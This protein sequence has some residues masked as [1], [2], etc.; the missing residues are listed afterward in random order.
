MLR[1]F[2]A[3]IFLTG[4]IIAVPNAYCQRN[5]LT[6]IRDSTLNFVDSTYRNN[7]QLVEDIIENLSSQ[8]N[9][10]T[11]EN[12]KPVVIP[13]VVHVVHHTDVE[14]IST[15]QINSQ[16]AILNNDFNLK[17]TDTFLVPQ[18][19]K[20]LSANCKISFK[21]ATVDPSGNKSDGIRRIKTNV[22]EFYGDEVK[23]KQSGGDNAWP[24]NSYLNIW[25]CNL[26]FEQ[27]DKLLLGYAQ[28]PGGPDSTDGV[29]I[30]YIA[31]GKNGTAE[32]P[33]HLGR[34]ATHEIGHWLGLYHIWGDE[35]EDQDECEGSDSV[36]DTP[37]QAGA[38][39]GCPSFPHF[40]CNNKGDLSVNYM[41]YSDD[42]CM[43]M[44]TKGQFA[45][46]SATLSGPRLA[47]KNSKALL[48]NKAKEGDLGI[49][50]ELMNKSFIRVQNLD[51]GDSI[52]AYMLD[53]LSNRPMRGGQLLEFKQNKLI[54]TTQGKDDKP[55]VEEN[56]IIGTSKNDGTILKVTD[57]ANTKTINVEGFNG[58]I[59]FIKRE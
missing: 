58:K 32:S 3:I 6:E 54:T 51:L 23:F 47:I 37:E 50:N 29:V 16:I 11:A 17:N 39:T 25:V 45:R 41:D 59:L 38:N 1:T 48:S 26:Q 5:C 34:T 57:N 30:N 24:A 2:K 18:R 49:Y 10:R 56:K 52:I 22:N 4:F 35:D 33:F 43:C 7:R 31:F 13:V 46:M 28:F 55:R 36:L 21:L 27:S 53:T 40:S 20:N 44:F 42:S 19:Y 9:G 8:K 14:N 12:P 15:S